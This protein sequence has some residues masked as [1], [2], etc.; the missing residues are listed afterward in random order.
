ML[1]RRRADP[2]KAVGRRSSYASVKFP[3]ELKSDR[4]S[5][6]AQANR[7]LTARELTTDTWRTPQHQGQ[8]PWPEARCEFRRGLGNLASPASELPD[9][10]NMNNDGM[11][12]GTALDLVDSRDRRRVGCV[13]AQSVDRLG[14]K[15]NQA[16][17]SEYPY[18]VPD[19]NGLE[20]FD[21]RGQLESAKPG[22]TRQL[23]ALY[24][25]GLARAELGET[26]GEFRITLSEHRHGEEARVGGTRLADRKSR[27]R[28]PLGHLYDRQQ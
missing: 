16:T 10:A 3:E 25:F 13:G 20:C 27:D 1:C 12:R 18:C 19:R 23:G 28:N 15:G 9:I 26:L 21:F 22:S 5:R 7:I 14:G 24:R 8:R 11:A 6:N 17:A 4:M 2:A